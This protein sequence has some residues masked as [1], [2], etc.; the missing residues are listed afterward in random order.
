MTG[1]QTCA[2]PISI[3]NNTLL[4]VGTPWSSNNTGANAYH[5]SN[6]G[7]TYINSSNNL[8]TSYLRF[9][10]KIILQSN[11]SSKVPIL[12]DMRALALQL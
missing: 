7:I 2:L 8:Y 12:D 1:V 11:D 10:T 6:A 9:Q 4:T 5:V 3:T